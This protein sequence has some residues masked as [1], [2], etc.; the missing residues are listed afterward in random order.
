MVE[1]RCELILCRD[2][3]FLVTHLSYPFALAC[4]CQ[5]SKI[6]RLECCCLQAALIIMIQ[7]TTVSTEQ[8]K[9]PTGL[10]A[11]IDQQIAKKGGEA[12]A[13]E[14]TFFKA[15]QAVRKESK[16]ELLFKTF[17]A[18]IPDFDELTLK[19]VRPCVVWKSTTLRW[20]N[21]ETLEEI[22]TQVGEGPSTRT[23]MSGHGSGGLFEQLKTHFQGAS[24]NMEAIEQQLTDMSEYLTVHSPHR[25]PF[26]RTP[27]LATH[28]F[29]CVC[30]QKE[31]FDRPSALSAAFTSLNA[32]KHYNRGGASGVAS[33][34]SGSGGPSA[35]EVCLGG[36]SD[37]VILMHIT[38]ILMSTF[39]IAAAAL[40]G[41]TELAADLLRPLVRRCQGIRPLL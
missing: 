1:G 14:V 20:Y 24:I 35:A 9:L 13:T 23:G 34:A 19:E 16:Y 40:G 6:F 27:S 30:W 2:L 5:L 41:M 15:L 36:V 38:N 29:A 28:T 33:G 18:S 8:N 7:S 4:Y 37:F 11:S 22:P 12:K 21:R 32:V 39:D 10:L 17:H 31:G 3:S 26:I 25:H